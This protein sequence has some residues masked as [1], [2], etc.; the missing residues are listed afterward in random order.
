VIVECP[1]CGKADRWHATGR[2]N[3]NRYRRRRAELICN[4]CAYAFSSGLPDAIAAGE[5]TAITLPVAPPRDLPLRTARILPP[6]PIDIR[7]RR[8][9]EVDE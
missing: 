3:E 5:A 6:L 7:R 1:K 4:A 2:F 8:A 9:G